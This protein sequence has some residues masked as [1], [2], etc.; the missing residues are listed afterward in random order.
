MAILSNCTASFVKDAAIA[1]KTGRL[2]A[3]PTETV[4]GLGADATNEKAV[5]RIYEVKARPKDHPLIVHI[6]S[7]YLLGEWAID[8]PDYAMTLARYFWPGPLTLILPKSKL[9][10]DFI[11]G[12][13]NKVAIRSPQNIYANRLLQEFEKIG[14]LGIVAPSANKFGKVS[15]TTAEAVLDFLGDSLEGNDHILDGGQCLIG[16]ESTILD[17]TSNI[18]KIVRPGFVSKSLVESVLGFDLPYS[19]LD[20]LPKDLKVSGK[21]ESHYSPRASIYLQGKPGI[22]DGFI[23]LKNIS[24]PNGAIRLS[25][26]QTTEELA[27]DLYE[28]L[29]KA[30]L[31]GIKKVFINLPKTGN[32]IDALNDRLKK[33]QFKNFL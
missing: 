25:M 14:G 18:P 11:T 22:G 33:A 1:L 13:Q 5:A 27:R 20:S 3:F 31:L 9:A 17:C 15:A 26:P 10:R 6:S 32:L 24:T 19:E 16:I 23:A 21:Y 30:D 12:S 29:R 2:V 4:Y 28:L 8:I 7:I